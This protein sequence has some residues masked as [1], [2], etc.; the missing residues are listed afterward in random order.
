MIAVISARRRSVAGATRRSPVLLSDTVTLR[1]FARVGVPMDQRLRYQPV[2]Q[3]G[4]RRGV[5]PQFLD[6]RP[7][8][9][10]SAVLIQHHECAELRQYDRVVYRRN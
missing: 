9:A 1:R 6:K 4:G 3:S 7:D 10:A 8:V 2:T 5:D